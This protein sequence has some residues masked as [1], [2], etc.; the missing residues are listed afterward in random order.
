VSEKKKYT[1]MQTAFLEALTGEARGDVRSAMN[2]AGYSMNTRLT[3][4]VGPLKDEIIERANMLLAM[5]SPKATFSMID[6]LN[7]PG[8]MGARNAVAA[9][10]QVLDRAGIVKKEQVEV[11]GP[12]GG[13]FILPP[14]Q[15]APVDDADYDSE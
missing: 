11:K 6:V 13:I 12:E 4:V 5:N 1:E 10:S 14:K 8:S 3:E 2:M 15:V 9:A 7:D